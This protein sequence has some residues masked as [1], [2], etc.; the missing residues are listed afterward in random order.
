MKMT[1][2]THRSISIQNAVFY[3][4]F[5]VIIGLLGYLSREFYVQSD[6][7]YGN[8]NTLT[9]ST[10]KLLNTLD[11]PL[12]FVAYVPDDPNLQE[13]LNKLVT[14][15]Q[16]FKSDTSIEFV[17]P[18]LD[19]LRARRDGVKFAG[20][21]AIHLGERSEIVDSVEE[22]TLVNALQRLSRGSERLVVF[23][24]GHGERDVLSRESKG[25]S[26]LVESLER[27][28]FS[29]QPHNLVRSQSIPQN[30]EF[31][32]IASPQKALLE[33][34]VSVIRDYVDNGG[35]LLWMHDPGGLKGLQPL[36]ELL[37]VRVSEGTVVDANEALQ[38]MLGINHP[39]VVPV[40]DY[41]RSPLTE[42]LSGTQTLFPFATMV[43]RD[44]ANTDTN[45]QYDEFLTTLPQSWLESESIEGAIQF[46]EG[47]EDQLGPVTIGLA[48]TRLQE[49][50]D[51][52]G[53]EET[54]EEQV[55]AQAM[56]D[57][58]GER[59]QRVVVV[60]DSD[61]MLNAFV[62]HAANLDLATNIFNWLAADDDLLQVKVSSA[63]DTEFDLGETASVAL[64]GFFLLILPVGLLLV[65][66]I[67]W[68]RRRKR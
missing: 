30:A 12:K 7:T 15:Y 20:Q 64:A 41:G 40:V 21:L 4:L 42:E 61:F 31:L 6:W 1:K 45:W 68:L 19:P 55:Q 66:M 32:V 38:I 25:L 11:A 9:E 63:P 44:P 62:G 2:K 49:A 37:G 54:S 10:Q 46:D 29:V 24:E 47:G 27:S 43:T 51:A 52:N 22:Q 13:R 59:Q 53:D 17:N 28:G 39:A 33:G 58:Q 18:D 65:G 8:R 5:V 50:P 26:Q 34:E 67:I 60:G 56:L 35:N 16:R 23:L 36:A 57:E 48:L 3:I 14:K